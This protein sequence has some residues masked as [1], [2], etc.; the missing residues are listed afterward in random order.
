MAAPAGISFGVR[1]RWRSGLALDFYAGE[2]RMIRF[3]CV[4]GRELQS[5]E[6]LAGHP[7]TCPACGEVRMV[8]RRLAVHDAR[9]R[10]S[11]SVGGGSA[12]NTRS[13]DR[14]EAKALPGIGRPP[15]R[16]GEWSK[17]FERLNVLGMVVVTTLALCLAV[18][19]LVWPSGPV[20]N[21]NP[22]PDALTRAQEARG[23]L[24]FVG[25]AMVSFALDNNI[26]FPPAAGG[27]GIHPNLSWR[28]T[29]LPYIEEKVLYNQFH[30]DEPWDSPHNR[31]LLTRMP[32]LYRIPETDDPPGM[33]RYRVF[34]GKAAA[35]ELP[36]PG[37]RDP[38]GRRIQ[39]FK[40]LGDTILVVES[41][42]PVPWTKP[43]ELVYDPEGPL[44]R[45]SQ[46]A[47][48]PRALMGGGTDVR[49]LDPNMPEAELRKLIA[50]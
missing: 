43:D 49:V 10:E 23:K 36:E 27:K 26:A 12:R 41:A 15:A 9:E 6:E 38:R 18:L 16:D 47:G 22:V 21:V 48:G 19:P 2:A 42:D 25:T 4:C 13:V 20:G 31:Q 32:D 7:G 35:F 50:P 28:V 11:E 37:A 33:T 46:V 24:H 3:N 29:L 8:P 40:N 17:T 30:L 14:S 5:P 39:D 44:P 45:L 34:V 1:V